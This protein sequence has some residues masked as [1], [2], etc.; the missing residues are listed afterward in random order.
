MTGKI[1]DN[2]E[3]T[4][5]RPGEQEVQID[6]NNLPSGIYIISVR[7]GGEFRFGKFIKAR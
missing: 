4:A 3:Y 5:I 6:T 1:I 2:Q 7:T